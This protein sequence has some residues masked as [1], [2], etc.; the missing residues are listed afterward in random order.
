MGCCVKLT[1]L[2][3]HML[4][5]NHIAGCSSLEEEEV[6]L[7]VSWREMY[8]PCGRCSREDHFWQASPTVLQ[9]QTF[10]M[11]TFCL[12]SRS[13]TRSLNCQIRFCDL[14]QACTW[15]ASVKLTSDPSKHTTAEGSA[16]W[17]MRNFTQSS[18]QG[19]GE[20]GKIS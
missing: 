12:L 9:A 17:S 15:H 11:V 2:C 13:F 18:F 4:C 8:S 19:H 16:S 20:S 7:T 10:S 5:K 1:V 6:V 14:V 3:V